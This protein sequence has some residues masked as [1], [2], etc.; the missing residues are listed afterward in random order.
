MNFPYLAIKLKS[1]SKIKSSLDNKTDD[2]G[3]ETRTGNV[4]IIVMKHERDSLAV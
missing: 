3:K 2:G 4:Y 1:I